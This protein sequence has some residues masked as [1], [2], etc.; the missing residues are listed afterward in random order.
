MTFKKKGFQK[1][2]A[3]VE[4]FEPP[5]IGFG[6]R[7]STNWNYTPKT[8]SEYRTFRSLSNNA[9]FSYTIH[10]ESSIFREKFWITNKK[11]AVLYLLVMGIQEKIENSA[12]KSLNRA[13]SGLLLVFKNKEK[14]LMLPS[15]SVCIKVLANKDPVIPPPSSTGH[16]KHYFHG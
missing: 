11:G 9:N 5:A 7:C 14:S 15:Y 13:S 10:V 1:K 16:A 4:G 6:D 8:Q 3:G 12:V 2:L